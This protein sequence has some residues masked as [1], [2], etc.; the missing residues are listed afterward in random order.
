MKMAVNHIQR[1]KT[2]DLWMYH[3]MNNVRHAGILMMFAYI[4]FLDSNVLDRYLEELVVS[5]MVS[6]GRNYGHQSRL[7]HICDRPPPDRP[8]RIKRICLVASLQ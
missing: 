3:A 6:C 2:P 4:I 5:L 7:L 1:N 8:P